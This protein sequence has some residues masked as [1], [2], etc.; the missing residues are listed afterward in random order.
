MRDNEGLIDKCLDVF[1]THREADEPTIL[2]ELVARGIQPKLA[3][4]L[5][6]FVPMAFCHRLLRG[7]GVLF[8]ESFLAQDPR[9]E[10]RTRGELKDVPLYVEAA[11]MAEAW[12][13]DG[14][15]REQWIAIAGRSAEYH[16][17]NL[18]I[19]KGSQLRGIHLAEPI[20][21]DYEE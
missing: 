10:A 15:P 3:W 11:E 17:I 5:I 20:L 8:P 9:T 2:R 19:G 4:Q 7:T 6:Q 21:F 16:V 1:L 18:F 12:I 14:V 13:A